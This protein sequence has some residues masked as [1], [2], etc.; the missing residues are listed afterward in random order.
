MISLDAHGHLGAWRSS[1]ELAEVGA[2]LAMTSSL[3]EAAEVLER[4]KPHIAWGVGCHP[5]VRAAQ[6]AFTPDRFAALTEH[7]LSSARSGLTA[8]RVYRLTSSCAH[9]GPLCTCST[10]PGAPQG[11]F[12]TAVPPS[13]TW[14]R[15][16]G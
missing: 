2:V 14:R 6:E 7:G 8:A 15:S 12:R 4:D 11:K 13:A 9:S 5:R 16:S 10:L 1:G 3:Q